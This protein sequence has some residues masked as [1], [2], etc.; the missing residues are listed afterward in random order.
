MYFLATSKMLAR[1][2]A[3]SKGKL[4]VIDP[5]EAIYT[6]K[7]SDF[8]KFASTFFVHEMTL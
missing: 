5:I 4:S 2:A 6:S 1:S 8:L 3:T 7:F